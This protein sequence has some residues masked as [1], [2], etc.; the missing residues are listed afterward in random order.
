V[1]VDLAFRETHIDERTHRC[2]DHPALID[3]LL[4]MSSGLLG[5]GFPYPIAPDATAHRCF[6]GAQTDHSLQQR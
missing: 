6:V 3:L 4:E 5:R 1:L 2:L